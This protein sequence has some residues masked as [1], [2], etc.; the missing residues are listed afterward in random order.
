MKWMFVL[1][2]LPAASAFG[3]VYK[4]P[5]SSGRVTFTDQPCAG[6]SGQRIEIAPLAPAASS[7]AVEPANDDEARKFIYVELPEIERE[8]RELMRSND[9]AQQELGRRM[10]WQAQRAREA[11]EE[12]EAAKAARAETKR[13]Y[14]DAYRK[15]GGY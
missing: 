6:S 11:H 9:P 10:A 3:D 5:D 8:A 7:R 13:R 12:V 4:C 15:F 2:A 1:L 14:E